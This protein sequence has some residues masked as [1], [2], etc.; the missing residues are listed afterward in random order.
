MK[1][2]QKTKQTGYQ[3]RELLLKTYEISDLVL[4]AKT[5]LKDNQLYL[6]QNITKNILER[7]SELKDINL[8]VLRSSDDK[9]NVNTIMDIIPIKTKKKGSLG[10]GCTVELDG[11]VVMLTAKEEGGKQVAEFGSTEGKMIEN[12]AFDMPGC[13][14]QNDIILNLDM[15]IETGISMTRE[16]PTACHRA[17]DEI[18]QEIRDEMKVG[19]YEEDCKTTQI[20]RET[21]V[22]PYNNYPDQSNQHDKPNGSKVILVKEMMGQGGMHDNIILPLEPCGVI[23]GKSVVD[24]GNIPLM[25]SPNE[26]KDGAIHAMTCVAPSTK[27]TTRHYSRDPLVERLDEDEKLH[28]NGI[29]AVGSPQ[30]NHEKEY[31]AKRVGMMIEKIAPD[32]VIVMTEGYGNNHIDFAKHI[33]EVGKRDIP[34]VG[35]TYAAKKG[36][37]IIGNKYMDAMVELSKDTKRYSK[38]KA[39][40]ASSDKGTEVLGENTLIGD[41]ADR[42]ISMLKSKINDDVVNIK[43]EIPVPEI[44]PVVWAEPP[45]TLKHSDVALVSAAGVHLKEQEPFNVAGDNSYR[46]IPGDVDSRELMVTHGGY[47]HKDVRKDINCMFPTDRLKELSQEGFIKSQAKLHIGFMGGGGDFEAFNDYVGPE[48]ARELSRVGAG[49]AVLTAG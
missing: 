26:V 45:K 37:L 48:I 39:H 25:L 5:Q 44:P 28:L 15:V 11:I 34:V 18:I 42:A 47:D 4:A 20:I 9:A 12:I 24:M 30:S 38:N 16:G 27:E 49:V 2:L 19:L 43:S 10:S 1:S 8:R 33:E 7:Y 21:P 40:K 32:G 17:A 3:T 46:I 31:T 29:I 36:A 14:D 6:D 41:D 35:V 23:G 22:D 13:P